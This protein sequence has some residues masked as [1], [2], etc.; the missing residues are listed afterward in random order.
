M[1]YFQDTLVVKAPKKSTNFENGGSTI[2]HVLWSLYMHN[3]SQAN[4]PQTK[5][6]SLNIIVVDH[7]Q[8]CRASVDVKPSELPSDPY[9]TPQT[10][11]R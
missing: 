3:L 9:P 2:F 11:C 1:K 5:S 4:N 6:K 10:F 7:D 8:S